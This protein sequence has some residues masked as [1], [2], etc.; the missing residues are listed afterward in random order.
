[1]RTL[2]LCMF[3]LAASTFGS[4]KRAPGIEEDPIIYMPDRGT[5]TDSSKRS[6]NVS[7]VIP[8]DC[9]W[10]LVRTRWR[11]TGWANARMSS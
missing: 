8:S 3:A 6:T 11:S 9:A 5:E 10:K 1:M 7:L 2:M 4:T